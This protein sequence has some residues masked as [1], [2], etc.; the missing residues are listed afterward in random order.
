MKNEERMSLEQIR[1]F[2]KGNKAVDFNATNQGELY[3]RT[4]RTLCA[5]QYPGL[6]RS[7]KGLG[8]ATLQK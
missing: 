6:G 7:E 8:G 4:A 1:A 3:K 5:Q 2:L